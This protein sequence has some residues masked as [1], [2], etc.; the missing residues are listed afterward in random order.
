[1]V[2]LFNSDGF[3]V[4]I[5][6]FRCEIE[7]QIYTTMLCN[8]ALKYSTNVACTADNPSEKSIIVGTVIFRL[9]Q[10]VGHCSINRFVQ[11]MD[12]MDSFH[13]MTHSHLFTFDSST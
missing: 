3:N 2:C 7:I 4:I 11:L 1:M 10:S 5:G 9:Q 13:S 12:D 6:L 8:F